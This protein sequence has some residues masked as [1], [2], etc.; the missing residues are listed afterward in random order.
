[1]IGRLTTLICP[2]RILDLKYFRAA[3]TSVKVRVYGVELH[4][5]TLPGRAA[6]VVPELDLAIDPLIAVRA[7]AILALLQPQS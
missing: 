7:T 3:L 4:V 1:M 2:A 5:E 6:L